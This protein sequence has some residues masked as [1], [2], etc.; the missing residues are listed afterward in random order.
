MDKTCVNCGSKI[1]AD[2]KTCPACGLQE[3]KT[4]GNLDTAKTVEPSKPSVSPAD[5]QIECARKQFSWRIPVG[6]FCLIF[7]G[8]DFA[9][10]LIGLHTMLKL[11]HG[12]FAQVIQE[13]YSLSVFSSVLELICSMLL[14]PGGILLL[15]YKR[16]ARRLLLIYSTIFLIQTVIVDLLILANTHASV[17]SNS[18]TMSLY[19]STVFIEFL[20]GISLPVF[21][22]VWLRLKKIRSEMREWE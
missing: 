20:F 21:L 5:S 3:G 14:L 15:G 7:G 17:K 13:W 22:Q 11:S 9:G 1:P 16:L 4:P 18:T 2:W 6:I 12:P 19:Y 10:S 8:H